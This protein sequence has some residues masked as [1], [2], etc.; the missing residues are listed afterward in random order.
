MSLNLKGE[1]GPQGPIGPQGETG[2]QGPPGEVGPKGPKG[3]TGYPG[4]YLMIA[5]KL[6]NFPSYLSIE[7]LNRCARQKRLPR[8]R[9]CKSSFS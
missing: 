3:P 8:L 6:Y 2:L 4:N 5:T 7:F 1:P 9:T